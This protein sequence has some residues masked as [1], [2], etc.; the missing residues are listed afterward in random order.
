MAKLLETWYQEGRLDSRRGGVD[1]RV[2]QDIRAKVRQHIP[3]EKRRFILSN[4]AVFLSSRR[5]SAM[6]KMLPNRTDNDI[7]NKWYSMARSEQRCNAK[8]R[9]FEQS[10]NE[11][12]LDVAYVH[13]ESYELFVHNSR[14]GNTFI[15][16]AEAP[17]ATTVEPAFADRQVFESKKPTLSIFD[18][19]VKFSPYAT[20]INHDRSTGSPSDQYATPTAV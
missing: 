13:P 12:N 9:Q 11:W 3:I 15:D 10:P 5:W 4:L 7:K 19:D 1:S 16:T 2:A 18:Y 17:L 6:A 14:D 20:E 8:S